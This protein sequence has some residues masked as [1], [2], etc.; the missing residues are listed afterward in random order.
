MIYG[1]GS[2]DRKAAWNKD[3]LETMWRNQTASR[4]KM[5]SRQPGSRLGKSAAGRSDSPYAPHV[6]STQVAFLIKDAMNSNIYGEPGWSGT[7]WRA[8]RDIKRRD[9]GGK[10]GTTNSSK[11]ARFVGY[12]PDIVAV[13]WIGF[14]ENA[15]DLRP[16]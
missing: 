13:V 11:D 12:G 6:V 16:W 5:T 1:E 14:D 2:H 3:A 9:L 15:R 4:R 7:G 8:M 10:T